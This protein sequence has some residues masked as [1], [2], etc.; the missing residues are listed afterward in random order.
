M[1][2]PIIYT[3]KDGK[4]QVEIY[5]LGSSVWLSQNDMA[6]LFAA[7][8]QNISLHIANI[9]WEKIMKN[10]DS[11]GQIVIYQDSNNAPALSIRLE[12]ETLWLTQKQLAELF[13][14]DKS[15][16]SRHIENIFEEQ[17]LDKKSTVAFFATVQS[18][19]NR[20]V[21]RKYINKQFTK[22]LKE[23]K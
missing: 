4:I 6:K 7:S 18:E 2:P 13:G 22:N 23:L 16:I 14:V 20:E 8:K 9:Q 12:N 10:I 1:H 17:E 19:G 3:T 15:S 11:K 21:S 5:E